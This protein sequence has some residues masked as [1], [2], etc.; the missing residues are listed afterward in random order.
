[1]IERILLKIMNQKVN[2][3]NSHQ[4]KLNKKEFDVACDIEIN[5]KEFDVACDTET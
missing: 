4:K 5:K 1:M 3:V 2:K